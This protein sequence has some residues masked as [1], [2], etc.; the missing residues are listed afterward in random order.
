M[1]KERLSKL[2]KWILSYCLEKGR[3]KRLEA[4][5][6]FGKHFPPSKMI[7][8]KRILERGMS[9]L[10]KEE[11]DRWYD[12]EVGEGIFF[13]FEIGKRRLSK[14]LVF[15]SAKPSCISTRA[16]EVT[17]SRSFTS[18]E[19]KGLI[20]GGYRVNLT[21]K[22]FLIANKNSNSGVLLTFRDYL[23]RVKAQEQEIEDF[24]KGT[25]K[26][27]NTL[28]GREETKK[29]ISFTPQAVYDLC[30]DSCKSKIM[31]LANQCGETGR[32]KDGI[33]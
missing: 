31:E 25:S 17:I 3:I 29:D 4:R 22:G 2:Q 27:I 23:D 19:A 28:L 21:E 11:I 16:I 14:E 5:E 1:A 30:C 18:L 26:R 32:L 24:L 7:R 15:Y 12:K 33:S 20:E 13:D 8:E 10:S 9:H 6:F